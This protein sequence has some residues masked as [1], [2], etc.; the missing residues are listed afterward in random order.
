MSTHQYV[1][2]DLDDTILDHRK[3]EKSALGDVKHHF[4]THFSQI[5]SEHLKEVYH[6]GNVTLWHQYAHNEITKAELRVRR[7]AVLLEALLI[8]D[9]EPLNVSDFYMERYAAYWDYCQ[10]ARN[11]FFDIARRYPVGVL[12]NGFAEIQ[13]AKMEQFKEV[14]DVLQSLVISEEVGVMKPH[15]ELFAHAAEVAQTPP[16]QIIYIG[17]SYRSDVEGATQAGW[18]VIWYAPD[19]VTP[20]EGIKHARDW[21]TIG[22]LLL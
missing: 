2:F 7:F 21:Q 6:Q 17:D 14:R 15:P 5:E 9:L 22:S 4:S 16:D 11:V 13:H 12:T 18:D 20:P 1:Y 10:D 8:T 19:V 3:A